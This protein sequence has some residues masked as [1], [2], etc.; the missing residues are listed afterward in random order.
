M[1]GTIYALAGGKGGVGRTTAA[2]N[3]GV[4]LERAGYNTVI[5]DADIAMTDATDLFDLDADGGVHGIL[6]GTDSIND[7]VVDGPEGVTVVPGDPSLEAFAEVDESRIGRITEPLAAAHDVILV[8]TGPGLRPLHR[9]IYERA[10]G[11]VLVTT[12]GPAGVADAD[13][14][15]TV[16]DHV[17]GTVLGV[18][19]TKATD[20]EAASAV[21]DLETTPLAVVPETPAIS[22]DDALVVGDGSTAAAAYEQLADAIASHADG[23]AVEGIELPEPDTAESPS[24]SSSTEATDASSTASEPTATSPDS[25][26]SAVSEESADTAG[27]SRVASG[28]GDDDPLNALFEEDEDEDSDDSDDDS[29]GSGFLSNVQSMEALTDRFDELPDQVSNLNPEKLRERLERDEDGNLQLDD[30]DDGSDDGDE[31]TGSKRSR[32]SSSDDDDDDALNALFE[33]DE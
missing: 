3:T 2:L 22:E 17:G 20:S 15:A 26:A 31:T 30:E 25:E 28:E 27:A 33:D 13:K 11:T 8:D 18:A 21:A 16:V 19:V 4:A 23:D 10:D 5:V 12:P 14:T 7:A 9:D 29:G 32:V 6:A 24:Q 1:G